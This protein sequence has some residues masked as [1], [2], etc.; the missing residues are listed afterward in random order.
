MSMEFFNKCLTWRKKESIIYIAKAKISFNVESGI[1]K[2]QKCDF[3]SFLVLY[4][5]D[6]I[7]YKIISTRISFNVSIGIPSFISSSYKRIVEL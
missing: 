4:Y 6:I 5:L 1:K 2:E 3:C 7:M